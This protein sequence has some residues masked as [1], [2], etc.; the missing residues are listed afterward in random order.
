MTHLIVGLGNPGDKYQNTRHNAG[1]MAL[2]AL[3]QKFDL[4]WIKNKKLNCEM[5]KCLDFILAKPQT[6]MNNSGQAVQAIISYF[7]LKKEDITIIHD[8]VDIELGKYKVSINSRPAGH[9]GVKSIIDHLG[10][11]DFKRIRVGIKTEDLKKMPTERFV[12]Q[13]FSKEELKSINNV[14]AEIV[15]E[16]NNEKNKN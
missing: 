7:K 4:L 1:F 15:N 5:S 6:Y 16:I 10:T 11:K 8:E 3:A 9:N 14:I 2:D 12:M 13:K